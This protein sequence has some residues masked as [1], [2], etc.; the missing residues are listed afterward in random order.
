MDA[1]EHLLFLPSPLFVDKILHLTK[2]ISYER[3][4]SQLFLAVLNEIGQNRVP[5][6]RCDHDTA[7]NG[8]LDSPLGTSCCGV[9]PNQRGSLHKLGG[10]NEGENF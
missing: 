9:L 8:G 7:A 10:G 2:N 6:Y 3:L 4:D 5:V 1:C